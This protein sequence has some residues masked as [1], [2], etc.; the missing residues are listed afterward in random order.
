MIGELSLDGSLRRVA[1]GLPIALYARGSRRSRGDSA[2]RLRRR[3]RGDSRGAGAGGHVAARGRGLS[4]RRG[5]AAARRRAAAVGARRRRR[6]RSRRRARSRVRQAGARGRR[7][8]LAQPAAHRRARLG[9]EH[10]R[11]P[12]ADDPAAARR[13][14]G[15]A[16][17]HDLLRRRQ[18]RRR[19]AH[20][21]AAVSRAAPGRV[22]RRPRRWRQRRAQAGRDQPGAQRRAVSRRAARVQAP[23]A[24]RRCASRSKS[25]AVTIV[26]ARHAI[27]LPRV[28]RARRG[29]EPVSLRLSRLVAARLHLRPRRGAAV[30]RA[31]SRG[32]CSTVSIC[33]S[34]CRRSTTSSSPPSAHGE[35]SATV[36]ERVLAARECSG[37]ASPGRG[38][39]AN[40]QM[41]PQQLLAGAGSTRLVRSI[42]ADRRKS[43]A[44]ARAACIASC[45]SRARSPISTG[46]GAIAR[47]HLQCAIDFRALDQ[48]LR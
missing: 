7:R 46:A 31:A 6:R 4:A 20:P 36:R 43:A 10:A 22:A 25:D 5:D 47:D 39:H 24:R 44:S 37:T 16:D 19:V 45:A 27:T 15:A 21:A 29:D 8:R 34:R 35:P 12:P 9:Q 14:R 18:A 17:E 28:V 13:G 30:S 1:G 3:G 40:A 11:A 23:R 38:L 2:A 42:S 32:R 26:R 41:G 33:R 48:E